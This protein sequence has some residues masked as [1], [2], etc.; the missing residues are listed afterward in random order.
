MADYQPA[1]LT[2]L[3]NLNQR[4][5]QALDRAACKVGSS[6]LRTEFKDALNE[7]RSIA[8]GNV[9]DRLLWEIDHR[10]KDAKGEGLTYVTDAATAAIF[11]AALAE[12]QPQFSQDLRDRLWKPWRLAMQNRAKLFHDLK[13]LS[14][15]RAELRAP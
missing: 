2:K 3:W 14:Q 15:L 8:K 11:G 7:G 12:H 9:V 1:V 13:E 4:D 5:V 10:V 6:K